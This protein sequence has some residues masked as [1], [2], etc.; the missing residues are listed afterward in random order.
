MRNLSYEECIDYLEKVLNIKLFE[1]QKIMLKY[2]CEDKEFVSAR[3][4]GRS[5]IVDCFSKYIKYK[6][7]KNDYSL[8]NCERIPYMKGLESYVSYV[9]ENIKNKINEEVFNKE[10]LCDYTGNDVNKFYGEWMISSDGYYPYCSC[11]KEE[12]KD[13]NMPDVCPNCGAI[14]FKNILK[15]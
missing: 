2:L 9:D 14:M 1:H 5:Y 4:L 8:D 13:G 7:D 11:C 6:Y 12:P 10:Y 15:F 3:G